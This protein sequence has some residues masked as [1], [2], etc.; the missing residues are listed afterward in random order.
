M[1]APLASVSEGRTLRL[2]SDLIKIDSVNPSLV[3]G[4]NGE[5]D[6]ARFLGDYMRR[7]GLTVYYQELGPGRANII[8][9][10]RGTGGGK[11]LL[12]NGHIDTV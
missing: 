4:G 5:S 6:I 11:S 7:M 2:L 9:I 1:S 3:P 10:L 12:L 8:G